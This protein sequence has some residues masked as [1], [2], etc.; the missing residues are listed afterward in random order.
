MARKIFRLGQVLDHERQQEEL[1]QRELSA[2]GQQRRLATDALHSLLQQTQQ[3]RDSIVR[4]R[5][6]RLDAAELEAARAYLDAMAESIRQQEDVVQT[7]EEQVLG[8]REALLEIVRRKRM[9]EGLQD[10]HEAGIS[11]GEA[12]K[13]QLAADEASANRLARALRQER[14]MS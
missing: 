4:R 10:R 7:L 1:A 11:A 3:L 2:L 8:S 14:V 5:R 6:E 12:R 9:L 13:E